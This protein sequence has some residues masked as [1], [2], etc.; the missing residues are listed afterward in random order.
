M[1][2]FGRC[3]ATCL[4]YVLGAANLG[5]CI[6]SKSA[7]L[8]SYRSVKYFVTIVALPTHHIGMSV[9]PSVRFCGMFSAVLVL[10]AKS[11]ASAALE[12]NSYI[13]WVITRRTLD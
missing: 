4:Y 7:A 5:Y 8:A 1:A 10:E 2:S 3:N 9:R 11:L 13:F 12:P 6:I